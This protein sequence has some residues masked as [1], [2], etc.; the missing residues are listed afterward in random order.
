M[1]RPFLT[2]YERLQFDGFPEDITLEILAAYFTL[3]KTDKELIHKQRRDHN[4]LGF[5]LQLCILR[6]LGFF[7][8][9]LISIAHQVTHYLGKQIQVKP[10]KLD[11]YGVREQTRTDHQQAIMQHLDFK[12]ADGDYLQTLIHWLTDRALEHDKPLLLLKLCCDKLRQDKI[13]RPG[14]T[15]L[16]GITHKARTGAQAATYAKL[17]DQLSNRRRKI[18]DK[19]LTYDHV[20]NQTPLSWLRFGETSNSSSAILNAIRKL[21]YL[22]SLK[23]NI[24]DLSTINPNRR[25]WL[26]CL[27]R[28]S[29]NQALQ[30]SE[31][32]RRYPILMAFLRQTLEEVIDEIIE[33]FDRC[34]GD[35][36]SRSKKDL[37]N[38]KI[39]NAKASNEKLRLFKAI[40][41]IVLNNN[42]LDGDI[43]REIYQKIDQ[44]LLE[45]SLMECDQLIRPNEHA[46]DFLV[47]R[48]AYL[49]EF[50]P[51]F[52]EALELKSNSKHPVIGAIETL[53]ILNRENKK[54][55]PLDAPKNFIPSSWLPYVFQIP[56]K[57]DRKYYE[58]CA[59]F[60]L[61]SALRS[62]AVWVKD[63]R[64][65]TDPESYLVPP[66][67]WPDIR[68]EACKQLGLPE[69]GDP[70][71]NAQV[72]ELEA[73]LIT[74]D[75]QF[76]ANPNARI[77]DDKLVLSP[78]FAET[79]SDDTSY[80][81]SLITD[82]LPRLD[83]TDLLVEVD[84]WSH[85][86]K[87][88]TH[89][90]GTQC[91]TKDFLV[92]LYAS[93][94]SQACNFGLKKMAEITGLSY[95]KLAWCTTW[96]LRED[97]IQ[98]AINCLVNYQY[99]QPLSKFLGAGTMSSSDGQRFPVP[100]K[101][102]NAVSLP[103]YFG[104]GK[105]LTFYTWTSDQFSQYGSKVISSTVRDATYVLDAIL[106]NET[107]LQRLLPS[108]IRNE[109]L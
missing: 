32:E 60:E 78:L 33:L 101:A 91:R 30:R 88:F 3:M 16:E 99:H 72:L 38:L 74:T 24:W 41:E 51:K 54:S 69:K 57:A 85:F 35:C 42:V 40:G 22:R 79:L 8:D 61:R 87:C 98:N 1:P 21:N 89:V 6:Y 68:P 105:G 83:I 13:V 9:D 71:I 18:L 50:T 20:L 97:T 12:K 52:L 49:R 59:F 82:K 67:I 100:I 73:V 58:I 70:W 84:H 27:G 53:R 28:Q 95:D 63:S 5:A 2:Q 23:V 64:K 29:S 56:G 86:S 62:G 19:T 45:R 31:P 48:F 75:K 46:Y 47:N 55:L 96:F 43:R 34:L 66:K 76:P 26:A 90:A 11:Q 92:H 102:R 15:V 37:D 4:K 14:L 106:D 65:Y 94:L 44:E 7:L 39:L 10:Q 93:I 81:Q 25:K 36:H 109:R 103:K 108:S 104:Y 17:C 77:E 107:E 80:L